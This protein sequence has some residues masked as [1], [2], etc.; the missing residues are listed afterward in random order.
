[1]QAL[2]LRDGCQNVRSRHVTRSIVEISANGFAGVHHQIGEYL[3]EQV[4]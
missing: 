1:V 4:K 3:I 2:F